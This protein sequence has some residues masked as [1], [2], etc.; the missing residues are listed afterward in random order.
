[1]LGQDMAV[2]SPSCTIL[3]YRLGEKLYRRFIVQS[4]IRSKYVEKVNT[5]QAQPLAL[6]LK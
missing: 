2:Y 6:Q 4:R 5:I 1:M 3:H